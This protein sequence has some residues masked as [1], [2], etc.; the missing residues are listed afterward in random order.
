M[1]RDRQSGR[2]GLHQQRLDLLTGGPERR[3]NVAPDLTRA[4]PGQ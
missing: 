3:G 4:T 2:I 1:P